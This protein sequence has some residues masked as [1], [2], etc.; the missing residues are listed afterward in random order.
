APMSDCWDN[1]IIGMKVE[2]ENMDSDTLPGVFS[3]AFW[4]ATV[5][6]ISG[7]HACLRFEGFGTDGSQDFWINLCSE[8]VH[9]VGWCATKGKPLIPPR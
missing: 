8:K 5:L 2:V 9:P 1:I 7:Y 4:V 3:H 6:R